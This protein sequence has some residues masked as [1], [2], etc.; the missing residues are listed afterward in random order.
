MGLDAPIEA[1]ARDLDVDP[2]ELRLVKIDRRHRAVRADGL[3]ELKRLAATAS[4]GVGDALPRL[5]A[6][7][8]PHQLRALLLNRD[9]PF[10]IDRE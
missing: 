6:R 2:L 3:E 8:E 5:R 7:E 1:Q 9:R 4:A 10:P